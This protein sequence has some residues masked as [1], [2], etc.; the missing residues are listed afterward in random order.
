LVEKNTRFLAAP[1]ERKVRVCMEYGK[2]IFFDFTYPLVVRGTHLDQQN[3]VGFFG[4]VDQVLTQQGHIAGGVRVIR[5]SNFLLCNA[6]K[7]D[8]SCRCQHKTYSTNHS[9]LCCQDEGICADERNS[10]PEHE[11]EDK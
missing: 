2:V 4:T 9:C 3:Q 11:G 6:R 1:L 10:H 7:Y 8:G 5:P